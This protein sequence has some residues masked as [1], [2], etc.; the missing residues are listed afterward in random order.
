MTAR[1]ETVWIDNPPVNAINDSVAAYGTMRS[2]RPYMTSAGIAMRSR[3][4]TASTARMAVMRRRSTLPATLA[5]ARS[6][7]P[8]ARRGF[9]EPHISGALTQRGNDLMGSKNANGRA[10][11]SQGYGLLAKVPQR[12]TPTSSAGAHAAMR[13]AMG[14]LK[15]SP[16]ST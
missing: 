9:F 14:P 2:W 6:A 7:F 5:M 12:I 10:H 16:S 11:A 8:G 1:V 3:D 13:I 4:G 15:D